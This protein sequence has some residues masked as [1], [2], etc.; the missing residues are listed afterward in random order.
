MEVTTK[1]LYLCP[2]KMKVKAFSVFYLAKVQNK[3]KLTKEARKKM[4]NKTIAYH[5][6]EAIRDKVIEVLEMT[7]EEAFTKNEE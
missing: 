7:E 3:M 6:S 4:L 5:R 2:V 1:M